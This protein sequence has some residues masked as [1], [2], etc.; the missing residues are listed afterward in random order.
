MTLG[1]TKK[2]PDLAERGRHITKLGEDAMLAL[3]H[4]HNIVQ[5]KCCL[6]SWITTLYFIYKQRG[7]LATFE[8]KF[9]KWVKVENNACTLLSFFQQ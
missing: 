7:K 3:I 9:S 8:D 6:F 2:I 4:N 5:L 1:Q